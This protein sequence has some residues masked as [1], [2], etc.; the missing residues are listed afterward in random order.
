ME[1]GSMNQ[2]DQFSLDYHWLY[3]D[4]VLA[5]EPFLE[6][7]ANL[8]D[9]IPPNSRLLDCSCGIGVH[10]FALARR[11]FSV[12]GAD[13]SPGMIARAQER[14]E[15]P[16]T[17]VP[18]IVSTWQELPR[19][20][21]QE[22]DVAFCLGNSI[23]H[24]NGRQEMMSSFQGIRTILKSNGMLVLDSR[25]W[26]KLHREKPRFTT[27][28]VRIRN[29]IRCTPLYVRSFPSSLEE[30]HLIEV[31]F[32]FDDQRSVYERH[33]S[34][35]YRPYGYTEICERLGEAGFTDIRSDFAEQKDLY[36]IT[37]R[38]G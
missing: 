23:G 9:S 28:G 18:F 27:M 1:S 12:S 32:I 30:E 5:G 3:S 35:A 15:D 10:A 8:L 6:Q 26:E 2:Y 33:Y 22:F 34:I 14:S 16:G 29:G 25:N 37:A 21:D 11:G 13:S 19:A 17:K 38:N 20:F 24:C 7:F 4:N 36:T 31:V